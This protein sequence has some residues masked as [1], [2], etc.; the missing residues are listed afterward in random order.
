MSRYD[1][2]EGQALRLQAGAC[3]GIRFVRENF[4]KA[5]SY[6]DEVILKFPD[7]CPEPVLSWHMLVVLDIIENETDVCASAGDLQ[8]RE[9]PDETAAQIGQH[10]VEREGAEFTLA[11]ALPSW[12]QLTTA[13]NGSFAELSGTPPSLLPAT[14][15]TTAATTAAVGTIMQQE[16]GGGGG[17]HLPPPVG[18]HGCF[19]Y[20]R[21]T[22]HA[23]Q[24]PEWQLEGGIYVGGSP[25]APTARAGCPGAP[26]AAYQLTTSPSWPGKACLALGGVQDPLVSV[27]PGTEPTAGIR[28]HYAGGNAT[29]CGFQRAFEA[30]L[31]CDPAGSP[32][33]SSSLSPVK[34]EGGCGS[35][36]NGTYI[37]TWST[38]L[39][40]KPPCLR[41]FT[42]KTIS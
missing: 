34:M 5:L 3:F 16:Q 10:F 11:H 6:F 40:R 20:P 31:I 7:G 1:S 26:A 15:T 4:E 32:T 28:L 21:L 39:V 23:A 18:E 19:S 8:Y 36:Y 17:F 35:A 29:G 13:P 37:F 9:A 27:L 22:Q 14:A 24:W 33:G 38:P 12:L 2:D 41:H 42:L 30:R 25:V